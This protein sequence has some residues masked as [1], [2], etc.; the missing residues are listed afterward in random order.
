MKKKS[1]KSFERLDKTVLGDSR[2]FIKENDLAEVRKL[3]SSSENDIT[4]EE[5]RGI[6]TI[7]NTIIRLAMKEFII[8]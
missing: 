2:I 7:L 8:R 5:I 1:Y 4:E 6:V 3:I